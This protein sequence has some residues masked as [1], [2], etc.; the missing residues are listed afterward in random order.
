MIL[1]Q[2]YLGI[3]LDNRL[4]FE[5]PLKVILSKVN[6]TKISFFYKQPVYNQPARGWQIT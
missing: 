1:S 3:V 2:K 5:E 4:S 6:K